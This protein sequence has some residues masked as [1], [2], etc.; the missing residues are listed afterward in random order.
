M[1][2][3]TVNGTPINDGH[4]LYDNDGILET[5]INDCNNAIRNI[6]SGNYVGFCQLMVS[7]VQKTANVRKGT[8]TETE[9]LTQRIEEL[10]AMNNRLYEQVTGLPVANDNDKDGADD[11]K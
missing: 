5:I 11:G 2:K 1:E 4:G 8:K 6:F 7:I 3:R 9:S 10:K